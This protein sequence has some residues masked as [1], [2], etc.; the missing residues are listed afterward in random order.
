MSLAEKIAKFYGQGKEQR[1]AEGWLTCCPVHGDK[2]PSLTVTDKKGG[3]VIVHCHAGCSFKDVLDRFRADRLLPAW[4]PEK[5]SSPKPAAS[6]K[7]SFCWKQAT[8]ELDHAKKY[9]ASRAITLEL[10]PCLA[11]GEYIDKEN[12]TVHMIVAA[13]TK[14]DDSIVLAVQRLF[15]DLE[16]H[17]KSGAKMLGNCDGRGIWFNRKGDVTELAIGEGI[18]TVLSIIQATGKNC[19]A[20]LST[21][22]MKK[23]IFPEATDTIYI[24]TDSD[25]VREVD[26]ASMPGQKAA[27]VM[28]ENF[29]ASREGRTAYIVSPDDS[30]FTG[31]PAKIDFNDLLKADPTGETIRARF[32][33]AVPFKDL[34]WKPAVP[35]EKE[36]GSGGDGFYPTDT[37]RALE[38]MNKKYAAVVLGGDFRIAK[39]GYDI[40]AKKNTLC[41][42]KLTSIYSYYANKKVQVPAGTNNG[43][44]YKEIAKVWMTWKGR[45]TYDEVVFDPS[46]I[47][48]PGVY[49]LF[50]GFPLTPKQ[51]D[52]SLMRKHIF[53]VICDGNAEHFEYVMAWMARAVQDPG[54]DKPGVA[55]VLKGGK[56]IG[57]GVFVNYFGSIFGEAFL[58][59]ADSESFTGRF[60]MHL[61]KSLVVFLDEAVWGGDKRAEGKLKQ[62]I[63]EPTV[64]FEPKGIDSITLGNYI[65]VIIASN[66]EWVVPATGDERRFCVLQPSENFKQN[67]EYFGKIIKERENGGAEAMMYDLLQYDYSGVDLRRAPV[68]TGLSDQVQASLTSELEFWHSLI[69]RGYLLSEKDTGRPKR[70]DFQEKTTPINE[71]WPEVV[72]K[73]EVYNEY[74]QWCRIKN[75]KYVETESRFWRS[76]KAIWPKGNM[77][78]KRSPTRTGRVRYLYLPSAEEIMTSFT[79]KTKIHFDEQKADNEELVEFNH[80]F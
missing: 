55:I 20:A 48:Q 19:V 59:I 18:E 39:E 75:E 6:E 73:H 12:K 11:W 53:E 17:T 15:I 60:N 29:E 62:L 27:C 8:R 41:F 32:E 25:P 24:C 36:S 52:W 31:S 43:T 58:P 1:N 2:C 3:G 76:T 35:A 22:G 79:K 5:K 34:T 30:C 42:L 67:T 65:N 21:A 80:Q 78:E 28:A 50:K 66:E 63:T 61:S 46:G 9:F 26:A 14:P 70:S 10:P 56:G 13:A 54:G 71:L 40:V 77:K 51:G 72:Y 47:E 64:L 23:L 49:N 38:K 74:T 44:E 45:R 7:E 37:L 4:E 69:E 68:T 16:D 33:K 57:K